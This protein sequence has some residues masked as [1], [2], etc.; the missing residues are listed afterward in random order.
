MRKGLFSKHIM[1]LLCLGWTLSFGAETAWCQNHAPVFDPIATCFVSEPDTA[2]FDLCG[3]G[4]ESGTFTTCYVS[5]RETLEVYV[6]ASDA[7]GDS[8]RISVLNA[9]PPALFRD[10]GNGEASF[11]WVPEFVGPWSSAQSPFELFFIASD[12]NLNSQLRVMISVIN[13][14][15]MPELILPDSSQVAAGTQ[16]VFQVS[17]EDPDLEEVTIEALNLPPGAIFDQS[18]GMFDWTPQL[19]DTGLWSITFQATDLSGGDCFREAQIRVI[20]PSS[21]SLS[22]G[23]EESL[24]GGVVSVPIC[25][26]NSDAVAGME[27]LIQFD[28]TVFTFM[29]LSR[30]GTRTA[31]WEYFVCHERARGLYQEIKIVGI[32]NF[33][34]QISIVPLLPDS[35]T[36]AYLSFK[37]TTDPYLNGL[38]IPLEFFSFDFTDNTLST[39]RGQFIPQEDVDLN[40]GGVLLDA[41]NTLVGDIN[42]NGLAFEVGDAVKLVAYLSGITILTPQQMINSDVNQDGR[43]ATLADLIFLIRHIVEGGTVP[44][45]DVVTPGEMAVVKITEKPFQTSIRLESHTPVGGAL[46]I[47]KGENTRLENVLL[48]PEAKDVDLYTS[49]VGDQFRVLIISQKAKP[50]PQKENYLFTFEGEGFDTIQI[51]LADQKGELLSVKQEHERSFLPT[52]YALHQ[53]YPNPFNPSTSIRYFIGGD[54]P[55]KVSLKIYN[56]AGQLVKT[57][58]DEEKSPGEYQEM[59]NGKNEKNEDVASGMY[60]YKLKVSDYAET[61]KMVLLK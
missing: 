1:F 54:S 22:L 43:M 4:L 25:L 2:D 39:T 29:G 58:V 19:A 60:F 7:E 9:P 5:E 34:N 21:F 12:G 51:T 49:R 11:L 55:A 50:L 27:L 57:L 6:H 31:N 15:R 17:A 53:N 16:L 44:Q 35:G 38:L 52:K 23:V 45:G 61:R 13:V 37:V 10:L 42:L 30:Q 46:V 36:I 41:G 40:N 47:F 20:L 14:N 24:L 56:V 48:S 3:G 33:P 26:V 8:I 59:W 32:A 18:S 28:S